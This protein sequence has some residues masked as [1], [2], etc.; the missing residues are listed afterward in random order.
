MNDEIE[1]G[2]YIRTDDGYI[3]KV[4]KK[5]KRGCFNCDSVVENY[6]GDEFD[7]FEKGDIYIEKHSPNIIDL[8]EVGDYVNGHL[9]V[10]ID[11]SIFNNNV[12]FIDCEIGTYDGISSFLENEIET[13]V[14]KEQFE[15]IMYRV[16]E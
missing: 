1:V 10:M 4:I 14:T 7:F 9:V 2:D 5:D 13:I 11:T 6:H 8:I 16:E 12:K 3:A 15:K